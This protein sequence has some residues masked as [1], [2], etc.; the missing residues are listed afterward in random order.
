MF[1]PTDTALEDFLNEEP[2]SD[3]PAIQPT[4]IGSILL[5][6]L[7]CTDVLNSSSTPYPAFVG[8]RFNFVFPS[9]PA[10]M[11]SQIVSIIWRLPPVTYDLELGLLDFTQSPIAVVPSQVTIDRPTIFVSLHRL[12][13]VSIQT[14]GLYILAARCNG[15]ILGSVPIGIEQ[16]G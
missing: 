8:V 3:T 7:P 10:V 16:G 11:E 4:E 14:P 2:L 15:N 12:L 13:N 5:G 9:F 6:I 1:K